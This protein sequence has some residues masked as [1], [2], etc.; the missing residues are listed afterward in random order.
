MTMKRGAARVLADMASY[1]ATPDAALLAMAQ[2]PPH[3]YMHEACMNL[4][5]A[6]VPP[7]LWPSAI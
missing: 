6:Q 3:T 7:P 2:V 4:A 5:V 1:P